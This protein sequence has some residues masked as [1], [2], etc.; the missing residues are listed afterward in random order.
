[1]K[2]PNCGQEMPPPVVTPSAE[3]KPVKNPTGLIEIPSMGYGFVRDLGY[4]CWL[5]KGVWQIL[6]HGFSQNVGAAAVLMAGSNRNGKAPSGN[7]EHTGGRSLDIRYPKAPYKEIN[8]LYLYT[9]L[10]SWDY[11]RNMLYPKA[12]IKI[13]MF[14]EYVF[15]LYEIYDMVDIDIRLVGDE[16]DPTSDRDHREH[17]HINIMGVR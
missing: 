5:Q 4:E 13:K 1:M 7:P 2:C 3:L 15:T 12:D 6:Y 10:D 16:D 9:L 11:A 8:Y 17:M 14:K